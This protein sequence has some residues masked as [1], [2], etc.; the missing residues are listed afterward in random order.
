MMIEN[1]KEEEEE[2]VCIIQLH[3]LRES[4]MPSENR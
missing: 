1:Y 3:V 2:G 4:Q